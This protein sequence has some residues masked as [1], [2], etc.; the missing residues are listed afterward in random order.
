MDDV[1]KMYAMSDGVPDGGPQESSLGP[2]QDFEEEEEFETSGIVTSSDDDDEAEVEEAVVI[3][4]S[5]PVPAKPAAEEGR[6]E[7]R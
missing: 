1:Y 6:Q 3:I 2:S 7:G 4:T 5:V